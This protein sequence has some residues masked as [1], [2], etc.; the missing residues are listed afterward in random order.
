MALIWKMDAISLMGFTKYI[1]NPFLPSCLIFLLVIY[2]SSFLLYPAL[3][4]HGGTVDLWSG[5]T[6]VFV[7]GIWAMLLRGA[8]AEGYKDDFY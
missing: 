1:F 4:S 6:I 2:F 7:G 3:N 8:L 5:S